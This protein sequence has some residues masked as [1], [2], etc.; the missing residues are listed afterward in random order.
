MLESDSVQTPLRS[1]AFL[2]G[3]LGVDSTVCM[4][5]S[6]IA[7]GERAFSYCPALNDVRI[8]NGVGCQ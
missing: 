3:R 8:G 5:D 4:P 1:F 2:C 7:I 6:V